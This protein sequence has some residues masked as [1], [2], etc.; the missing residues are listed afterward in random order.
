[1]QTPPI[2]TKDFLYLRL[3]GDR[4]IQEKDFGIIQIDR[5]LEM[6]KWAENI[7]AVQ[8][9]HAKFAIV[10]ANNHYAGFGPGTAN[11]FRNMLGLPE[12]KWE[13]RGGVQ[14]QEGK[15]SVPDLKQSTLSDF[16]D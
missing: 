1:M 13:D 7:K 3:I 15:Y 16:L 8:D 14:E 12:A 4:S 11:I 2:L 5:I 10:T 9:E 6:E